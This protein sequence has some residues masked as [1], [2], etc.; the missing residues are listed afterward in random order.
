M[1]VRELRGTK[2][3]LVDFSNPGAKLGKSIRWVADQLG[4]SD[5]ALTLRVYAHATPEEEADLSFA[6]F[7]GSYRLYPAPT[8]E[9]V[10]RDPRNVGERLARRE[11]LEP[12]TLRFEA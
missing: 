6:D 9:G 2:V 7:G 11:G 4:P 3:D 10:T 5:P 1:F 8:P 12:P